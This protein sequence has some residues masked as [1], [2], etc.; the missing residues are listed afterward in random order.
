MSIHLYQ[1]Y[2]DTLTILIQSTITNW[3]DIIKVG[4]YFFAEKC[5]QNKIMRGIILL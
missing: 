3:V 5:L 1:A 2:F 4:I